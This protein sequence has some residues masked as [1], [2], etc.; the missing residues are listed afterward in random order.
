MILLTPCGPGNREVAKCR[1]FERQF[2][3]VSARPLRRLL[4]VAGGGGGGGG[5]AG[6]FRRVL[7]GC[8]HCA[9]GSERWPGPY[10]G[11]YFRC[12]P[13]PNEPPE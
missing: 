7:V 3:A 12:G 8:P 9:Y 11:A 5:P 10:M 2:A 4:A 1:R 13:G 6:C